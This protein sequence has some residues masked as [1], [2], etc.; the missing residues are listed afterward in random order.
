MN[1]KN[2]KG[3]FMTDIKKFQEEGYHVSITSKHI[4]ITPAIE[5][6]IKEKISKIEKFAPHILDIVV[7]I[8]VQKLAHIVSFKMKFLHYLVKVQARTED[9]YASI[10]RAC[11]RLIKITQKYKTKMQNHKIKEPIS[12]EGMQVSILKPIS[13]EEE[14]NEQIIEENL[15]EEEALYNMELSSKETMHIPVLTQ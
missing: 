12:E 5:N 7:T 11:E 8:E 6:Y 13:Y 1:F 15:K 4:A 2:K 3:F 10:D 14:I 9:L